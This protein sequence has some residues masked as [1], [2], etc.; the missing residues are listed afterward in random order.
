MKN[1]LFVMSHLES[2]WEELVSQ[3]K[4]HPNIDGEPDPRIEIRHPDD[5]KA[6]TAD[7]HKN[8]NAKATWIT[9]VLYDHAFKYLE[10]C[11]L[12]PFIFFEGNFGEAAMALIEKHG[13][14]P[15]G[16]KS[17]LRL[18]LDR[19]HKLQRKCPR[20]L[21]LRKMDFVNLSFSELEKLFLPIL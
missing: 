6:L 3:L 11:P 9:V 21:W 18:R 1:I 4:Q 8:D 14:K 15:E 16:A 2:G 5:L 13:Y 20:S 17:Y 10:I 12:Y 7:P 19:M